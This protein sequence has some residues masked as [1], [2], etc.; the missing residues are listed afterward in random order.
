MVLRTRR[1]PCCDG[2]TGWVQRN[3]KKKGKRQNNQ[4]L[5]NWSFGKVY[6]LLKYKLEAKGVTI[7][8]VTKP[9]DADMSCLRK[10]QKVKESKLS[11]SMR[12]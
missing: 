10:P 2:E 3:T 11:L 7:E 5:S 6:S 8:K 1:K 4:K 12:L 9:Y